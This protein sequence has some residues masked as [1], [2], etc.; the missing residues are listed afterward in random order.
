M[1]TIF[2]SGKYLNICDINTGDKLYNNGYV[3]AKM[4]LDA[5]HAHMYDINGVVV[6]GSHQIRYNDKMILV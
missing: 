3:T 1:V 5:K 6:S 2:L 4:I